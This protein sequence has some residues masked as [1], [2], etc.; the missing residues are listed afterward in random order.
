MQ[1]ERSTRSFLR[2]C[3]MQQNKDTLSKEEILTY[4]P[5]SMSDLPILLFDE[6]DSTNNE[7][8]RL[9]TDGKLKSGLLVA[10]S[11]TGGRGR[12]G[13]TFYSPT[14]GIYMTYVFTP[15]SLEMAS[16]STTKAGVC[17]AEAIAELYKVEP[18]IKWVNDIY[19]NGKKVCGILAEAVTSGPNKGSVVVGIG[20]NFS[21]NEVPDEIADT[22]GF[23]PDDPTV[24]RNRLIAKIIEQLHKECANIEDVSYLAKYRLRSMLTGKAITFFEG[25][26]QKSA[27]VLDIDDEAGLVVELSDKSIRTLRNGEVFS[28]RKA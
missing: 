20:I 4:L 15:K 3:R 5:N 12:S 14:K 16:H 8:K 9:V 28:I 19:L 10:D 25:D 22:A 24:T 17:V 18:E 1:P 2:K 7:A 11:Q 21:W 27:Y 26:E 23:L 13:H 6:I